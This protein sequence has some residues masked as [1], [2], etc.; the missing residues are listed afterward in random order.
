MRPRLIL[1]ALCAFLVAPL[2]RAEGLTITFGGAAR[3]VDVTLPEEP[4]GAPIL[5]AFAGAGG[6]ADLAGF[7]AAGAAAG[8]IVLLPEPTGAGWQEGEEEVGFAL[9][10]L[11][12]AVT[13][14]GADPARAF[15]AGQGAGGIVAQRL[16]CEAG[17]SFR[18]F[19]LVASALPETLARACRPAAPAAIIA[20]AGAEGVARLAGD[21]A[22]LSPERMRAFWA[23]ENTCDAAEAEGET[24]IRYACSG[25]VVLRFETGSPGGGAWPE[26]ATAAL[27]A[28]FA[29]FGL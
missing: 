13:R 18:A 15:A 27:L 23:R 4:A 14:W 16:A 5:L 29:D 24:A 10:L 3:Q 7:A 12:E 1:I 19:G 6:A 21:G 17:G 2:A 26:G 20:I 9:A 22:L 28:F 8:A 11:A 25:G